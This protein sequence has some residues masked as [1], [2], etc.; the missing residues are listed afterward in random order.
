MSL[1]QPDVGGILNRRVTCRAEILCLVCLMS[2]CG[3]VGRNLGGGEEGG[4]I[5]ESKQGDCQHCRWCLNKLFIL[6][7]SL[8]FL[9]YFIIESG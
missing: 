8:C 3:G 5:T 9:C 4:A 1:P 7:F 2:A 6:A